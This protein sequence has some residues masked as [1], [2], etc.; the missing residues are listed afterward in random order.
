M[1][2]RL[3]VL[4]LMVAAAIGSSAQEPQRAGGAAGPG[5][6]PPFAGR[7]LFGALDTDHDNALNA[8]EIAA[9]ATGLKQLDRNGDGNVTADELPAMPAGRGPGGRGRGGSGVGGEAP[10]EPPS[11]E[12]LATTLMAFDRNKD[13]RLAKSE[14]PERLQ[15]LF[16]RLDENTDGVLTADEIKKG[17]AAQPLQ[18]PARGRG[19]GREGEGRGGP[20]RRDPFYA[21]LDKNGDGVLSADEITGAPAALK[22][23]DANGDGVIGMEEVFA[24]GRG[25][26]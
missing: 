15:G 7:V 17:A 5:G 12:E 2:F 4:V 1:H 10:A 14:A 22:A 20:P 6:V 18:T 13:G 23:L 3:A 9:A 26:L 16:A 19:E 8:A 25:R 11:P 24:P 21:A